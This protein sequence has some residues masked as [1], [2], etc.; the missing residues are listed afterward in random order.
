MPGWHQVSLIRVFAT[1]YAA[2]LDD[3]ANNNSSILETCM[4]TWKT[5]GDYCEFIH[6]GIDNALII[7]PYTCCLWLACRHVCIIQSL[8]RSSSKFK[9]VCSCGRWFQPAVQ[10]RDPNVISHNLVLK[11]LTNGIRFNSGLQ[12]FHFWFW[13]FLWVKCASAFGQS[14][15]ARKSSAP[16]I[17]G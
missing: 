1:T 9:E 12:D 11:F 8:L 13:T 7:P 15:F 10:H 17:M 5:N 14:S 4:T 16:F 2:A 6:V 3:Y